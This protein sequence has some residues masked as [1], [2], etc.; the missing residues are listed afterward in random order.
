MNLRENIY[1]SCQGF[2]FNDLSE[3]TNAK[4]EHNLS[5]FIPS[6]QKALRH[7]YAN[8]YKN[9]SKGNECIRRITLQPHQCLFGLTLLSID[10]ILSCRVSQQMIYYSLNCFRFPCSTKQQYITIE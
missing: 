1:L 10:N 7:R 9:V 2:D 5:K 6:R 3:A 4:F 8:H